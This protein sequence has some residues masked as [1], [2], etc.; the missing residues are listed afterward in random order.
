[1]YSNCVV[2]GALTCYLALQ[3][4]S[5]DLFQQGEI[6]RNPAGAYTD[7]VLA[8]QALRHTSCER[9][10]N[11]TPESVRDL[12][13][14]RQ[15]LISQR[16]D[17]SED[18]DRLNLA[19]QLAVLER[20]LS[21]LP[22]T[23]AVPTPLEIDRA[24]VADFGPIWALIERG[25]QKPRLPARATVQIATLFPEYA[26]FRGIVKLAVKI[27]RVELADGKGSI[28]AKT[29]TDAY[30]FS[31]RIGNETIISR[32]VTTACL[33]ILHSEVSRQLSAWPHARL[34]D[35][36]AS[37]ELGVP[38]VPAIAG[39]FASERELLRASVEMLYSGEDWQS[40]ITGSGDDDDDTDADVEA[41]RNL[42]LGLNPRARA[43]LVQTVLARFDQE[44]HRIYQQLL[45]PESDWPYAPRAR[46]RDDVE[47]FLELLTVDPSSVIRLEAISRTRVRLTMIALRA[48]K[49][50]WQ[51]GEWP[52]ALSNFL[53]DR[54]QMDPL[55]GKPF[56]YRVEKGVLTVSSLGNS[57]TGAVE[58][59]P[60]R[61]TSNDAESLYQ[62]RRP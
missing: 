31:H 46:T 2:I 45:R 1:V 29:M 62:R 43:E 51:H 12:A 7:Y 11:A 19:R 15:V 61:T 44:S 10:V 34:D 57:A 60:A 6:L 35:L 32:L 59:I 50:A 24:A 22:K 47:R 49:H 23:P 20:S 53:T 13:S 56:L 55:A 5:P 48:R 58:W 9:L 3:T 41:W 37:V 25:N 18:R 33:G 16:D 14:Q 30:K 54:E 52:A 39:A 21:L 8:A 17:A 26:G 42:M 36:C 28:A 27:A 4:P 40:L 38:A